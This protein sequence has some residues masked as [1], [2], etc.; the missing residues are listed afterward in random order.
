[1]NSNYLYLNKDAKFE[2]STLP[3]EFALNTM[4]VATQKQS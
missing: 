4:T 1:M 2:V 3:V